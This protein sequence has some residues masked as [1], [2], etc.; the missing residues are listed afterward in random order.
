[1][2]ARL[3]LGE[4]AGILDRAEEKAGEVRTSLPPGAARARM[5]LL[6]E[7]IGDLLEEVRTELVDDPDERAAEKEDL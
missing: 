6:K 7:S 3:K 2:S 4:L 5:G 1:M